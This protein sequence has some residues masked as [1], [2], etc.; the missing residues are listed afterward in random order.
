MTGPETTTQTS[1]GPRGLLPTSGTLGI[2]LVLLAMVC[3]SINDMLIKRLSGSYPLHEIVFIRSCLG[4]LIT[5]MLLK[6][7]GGFVLL[8][9]RQPGL[10][11]IRAL[12]IVAANM[13]YFLAL[14]A[15]PLAETTAIFYV[16]P[17]LITL[18]SIPLLG[19]TVGPRRIAAVSVGFLGVLIMLRP[20]TDS[21]VPIAIYLLPVFAALFYALMQIL[22]RKLGARST[23]SAMSFYIQAT[24]ILVSLLFFLTV[25]DGRLSEGLTNPS[26]LFLLRPWILPAAGDWWLFLAMGGLIGVVG[27]C[28]SQAYRISD[29]ATVAPFEYAAMPLA[30]LWGWL[31]FGDL[32]DLPAW[33]GILLI[34]GSGV[35]VFFRERVRGHSP[36]PPR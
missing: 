20:G 19:A 11:A 27:Y 2:A 9:T 15:L 5:T 34:G 8:R 22:T 32:P 25:G 30:V 28:L 10:H 35:Y 23:A 1:Q 16:A 13:T 12:L 4:I 31:A 26:L 18:L 3:I 33:T 29:P 14:A 21:E 24:F 36:A 6:L 17:L 7:E